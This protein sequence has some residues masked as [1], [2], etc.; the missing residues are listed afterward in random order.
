MMLFF[1]NDGI[2]TFGKS[3]PVTIPE[4]KNLFTEQNLFHPSYLH[5]SYFQTCPRV[6]NRLY[7]PG[8]R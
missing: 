8:L 5:A 4:S 6:C 7:F 2:F 3:E 1:H